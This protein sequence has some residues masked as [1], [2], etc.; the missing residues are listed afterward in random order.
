MT[1]TA[2]RMFEL[3]EPICL[4][5]FFADECNEELAADLTTKAATNAPTEGRQCYPDHRHVMP[6]GID[7]SLFGPG[8][9]VL[10]RL[11]GR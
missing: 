7:R 11:S 6:S 3:L 5:T 8:R 9:Q 1:R 10:V 4:V 2:R